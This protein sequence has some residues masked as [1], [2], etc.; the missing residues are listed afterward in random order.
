MKINWIKINLPYGPIFDKFDE[1]D[2]LT[3]K[4]LNKAGILIKTQKQEVYLIGDI[5]PLKGICDCCVKFD[6]HEIIT[7]YAIVWDGN[8]NAVIWE[9]NYD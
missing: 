9:G 6:K 5:N 8:Y 2:S 7:H 4:G 1:K 3:K